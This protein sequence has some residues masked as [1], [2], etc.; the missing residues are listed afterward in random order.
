MGWPRKRG[1]FRQPCIDTT[2]LDSS[3]DGMI[4]WAASIGAGRPHLALQVIAYIF[5][6]KDWEGSDAPK[7]KLLI[8][9]TRPVYQER[10]IKSGSHAPHAITR[11]THFAKHCGVSVK[12]KWLQDVRIRNILEQEFLGGLLYGLGS[13]NLFESWWKDERQQ[14]DKDLP[15]LQKAGV[16]VGTALPP[17]SEYYANSEQIIRNYEQEMAIQLPSIPRKLLSDAKAVRSMS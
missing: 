7:I 4:D 14:F 15:M 16:D 1:L 6:D 9:E 5:K 10:M 17:L 8:E 12:A 11:V 2:I 13:P 3:V